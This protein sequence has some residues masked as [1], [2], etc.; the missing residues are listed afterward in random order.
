MDLISTSITCVTVPPEKRAAP[1]GTSRGFLMSKEQ[2][3]EL[4]REFI[5][6]YHRRMAWLAL[7]RH[8]RAIQDAE[9]T[10][11][12]MDFVR[13]HGIDLDYVASHEELRGIVL[14]DCALAAAVLAL[15]RNRPAEAIDAACDGIERLTTHQRIWWE[16]NDPSESPNP[17]LVERL[18]N[19]AERVREN[20]LVKRT[21]REQLAIAVEREDYEQACRLRDQI[22][23]EAKGR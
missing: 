5:Q 6:L 11:A 20:Y 9:Q 14:F 2:C 7:G 21:L 18:R 8:D 13:R 15:K 19:I 17:A 16:E 23:A 3:A 22:K 10:I 12:L 1:R 4:D